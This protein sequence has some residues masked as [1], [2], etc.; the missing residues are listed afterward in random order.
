MTA[1]GAEHWV[2]ANGR[3][4]ELDF[5]SKVGP[6]LSLPTHIRVSHVGHR[7]ASEKCLAGSHQYPYSGSGGGMVTRNCLKIRTGRGSKAIWFVPRAKY[8]QS[9][10]PRLK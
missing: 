2:A 4:E 8:R 10:S 1:H 6:T 9:K 7:C 3:N 5:S